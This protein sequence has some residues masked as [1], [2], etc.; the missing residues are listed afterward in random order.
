MF[1][2]ERSLV[3]KMK[4]RPFALLGVNTDRNAAEVKQKNQ[5]ESITW[6]SWFDGSTGGPIC[7]KFHIEAFPT[8]YLVD[9]KG[10]VR[11]K[12]VGAPSAD[13]IDK[14]IE[15]LVKNVEKN[16]K[17]SASNDDKP[18]GGKPASGS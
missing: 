10:V 3:S 9:D 12:W 8:L 13:E 11:K 5:K 15:E 4:N 1:P 2:H 6:R 14:A 18:G 17:S 7:K 16:S